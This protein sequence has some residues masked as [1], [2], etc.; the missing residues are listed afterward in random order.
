MPRLTCTSCTAGHC[1]IQCLIKTKPSTPAVFHYKQKQ[2]IVIIFYCYYYH[3]HLP[4]NN[5]KIKRWKYQPDL[6]IS[7]AL[8][9]WFSDNPIVFIRA[10]INIFK[11]TIDITPLAWNLH[12]PLFMASC[13]PLWWESVVWNNDSVT[14]DFKSIECLRLMEIAVSTSIIYSQAYWGLIA[15]PVVMWGR[16][17]K[18]CLCFTATK[19][20]FIINLN[21]ALFLRINWWLHMGLHR[22]RELL[23]PE[24]LGRETGTVLFLISITLAYC[25]KLFYFKGSSNATFSPAYIFCF[26]LNVKTFYLKAISHFESRFS[27][28]IFMK[29]P[30]FLV[31]IIMVEWRQFWCH[32][33]LL[34]DQV[35]MHTKY[36][37]L[38]LAL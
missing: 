35:L 37:I 12:K 11:V 13:T 32:S 25:I 4:G 24:E 10:K 2:I 17:V 5:M 34:L 31:D 33:L 28:S 15:N 22:P 27:W 8:L 21:F 16:R 29:N 36:F 30:D 23:T 26:P 9:S 1:F 6:Q 38:A 14:T 18:G 7:T 20:Q 3:H 19:I